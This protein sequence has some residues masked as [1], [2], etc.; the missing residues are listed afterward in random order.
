MFPNGPAGAGLL[1]LRAALVPILLVPL[2]G[3]VSVRLSLGVA[4]VLILLGLLTRIASIGIGIV[5]LC[6]A[7]WTY[8][9]GG[10]PIF[11]TLQAHWL[12][13]L[14]STSIALVGPGAYSIDARLFGWR[15]FTVPE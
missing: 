13:L 11:G 15:E 9:S 12:I 6:A 3:S 4:A 7:L 1:A 14:A 10:L 8:W 5:A 2:F